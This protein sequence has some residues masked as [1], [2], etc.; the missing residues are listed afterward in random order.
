MADIDPIRF[1]AGG[2]ALAERPVCVTFDRRELDRILDLYGRMVA[3]GEW[4]DYAIDFLKDRAVFSIFRRS[5][6]YPI[7]R[8]EKDPALARRQG[9]YSV[10]SQ[11]GLIL[12]RGHD[13]ARVIAVLD[14]PLRA[15]N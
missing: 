11:T 15:V 2:S 6:E 10:V 5:T 1:P 4:R 8:I 7:Y 14:K 9:A 12:K 3:I 13:L